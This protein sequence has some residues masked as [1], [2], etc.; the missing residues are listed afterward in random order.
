MEYAEIVD[1][2]HKKEYQKIEQELLSPSSNYLISLVL[3]LI[4]RHGD[5]VLLGRLLVEHIPVV[6]LQVRGQSFTVHVKPL[7]LVGRAENGRICLDIL[8]SRIIRRFL[9]NRGRSI[10]SLRS[11]LVKCQVD[12]SQVVALPDHIHALVRV[13]IDHLNPE[14]CWV[15]D[16][17]ATVIE[18]DVPVP[19]HLRLLQLLLRGH[20]SSKL[21]V[22]QCLRLLLQLGESR[23]GFVDHFYEFPGEERE[24][25]DLE[26][27]VDD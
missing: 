8:Q 26:G 4:R 18:D 21:H 14:H 23:Q 7:F 13:N 5:N 19:E 11:S 25:P 3:T 10:R 24:D 12:W 1:G 27:N 15:H 9:F 20:A 17:M 22:R 16:K 2:E 6:V